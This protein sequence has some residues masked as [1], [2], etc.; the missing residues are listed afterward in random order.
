MGLSPT[1]LMLLLGILGRELLDHKGVY[2]LCSMSSLITLIVLQEHL[3]E[4]LSQSPFL[5]TAIET[6]SLPTFSSKLA[7]PFG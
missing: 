4:M 2:I 7:V 1:P 6:D 5:E 3:D